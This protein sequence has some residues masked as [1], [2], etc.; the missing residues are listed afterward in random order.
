MQRRLFIKSGS[1]ALSTGV[2]AACGGGGGGGASAEPN[3]S[4]AEMG[5]KRTSAPAPAPAPISAPAAS[6]YPVWVEGQSYAAG[7]IVTYNGQLYVA[8]FDNPGYNP[9]ISTYYW[10]PYVAAALSPAPAP[11]PATADY[12]AWVVNQFYAA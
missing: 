12:P 9:T 1:I 4:N 3:L 8:K 11:A 7:A 10:A 5:R 2:L 6:G